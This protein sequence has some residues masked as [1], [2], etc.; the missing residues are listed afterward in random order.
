MDNIADWLTVLPYLQ[1]ASNNTY[2]LLTH[3]TLNEVLY[4]F[5]LSEMLDL[6]ILTSNVSI[7]NLSTPNLCSI[8][9]VEAH[10]TDKEC[11]NEWVKLWEVWRK[12]LLVTI[13]SYWLSHINIK[14]IIAWVTMQVKYYYDVNQQPHFFAVEDKVL[15]QLHCEYKLSEVT[16]K[17]LKHQFVKLFK[18]TERIKHFTYCLDLPSAWK[19]HNVISIAHLESAS[20]SFNN[21]YNWLRLTHSS[22]IIVDSADNYYEIEWLLQK[23]VSCWGCGYTTEYLIW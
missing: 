11:I 13:I 18:V 14:D 19:I 16:N 2:W 23:W 12:N 1:A 7:F 15:L 3:Q 17:K 4:G 10:L 9:T 8:M 20:D 21:L 6:L 5:W 22:S